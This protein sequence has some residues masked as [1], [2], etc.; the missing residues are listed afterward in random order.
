VGSVKEKGKVTM[1]NGDGAL[2]TGH[3]SKRSLPCEGGSDPPGRTWRRRK[4]APALPSEKKGSGKTYDGLYRVSVLHPGVRRRALDEVSY[5]GT[6]FSIPEKSEDI[7]LSK[8][9]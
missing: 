7:F 4:A 8:K 1:T 6:F 3:V 9:K 2:R 5:N